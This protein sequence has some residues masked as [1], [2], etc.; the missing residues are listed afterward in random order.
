MTNNK[1]HQKLTRD[2]LQRHSQ[3]WLHSS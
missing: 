1:A 3:D 2:N